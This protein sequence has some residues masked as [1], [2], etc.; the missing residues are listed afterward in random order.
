[1]FLGGSVLAPLEAVSIVD[2]RRQLY[3]GENPVGQ[4]QKL[5]TEMLYSITLYVF[6]VVLLCSPLKF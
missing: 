4:N 3:I 2:A 1:M 6:I 5:G